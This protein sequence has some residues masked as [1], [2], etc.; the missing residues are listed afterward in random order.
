MGFFAPDAFL[1]A[2]LD[3]D[4]RRLVAIPGPEDEAGFLEECGRLMRSPLFFATAK[5]G[6]HEVAALHRLVRAGFLPVDVNVTLS[7]AARAGGEFAPQGWNGVVRP[8]RPEDEAQ[9]RRIAAESLVTSRFHL[10]PLLDRE[11]GPRV[12]AEW[13]GNFFCGKRGGSMVVAERDGVVAGFLLLLHV[14]DALV[15]DLLAVDSVYRRQGAAAAIVA[16][17]EATITGFAELKVGTQAANQGSVRFYESQGLRYCGAS[18]VLHA[19]GR[20]SC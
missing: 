1:S 10:D 13:A 20:P 3:R 16:Y 4:A 7:R 14:G 17:A 9:V 19:H 11:I 18:H 15:I 8:A 2:L 6:A 12:K 5:V